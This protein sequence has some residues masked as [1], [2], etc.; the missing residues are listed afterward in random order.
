MNI[1]REMVFHC[2]LQCEDVQ[3]FGG[4]VPL[5]RPY[6]D[7]TILSS[8][9]KRIGWLLLLFVTG[10]LTGT[11]MSRFS[12][13][14]N[15]VIILSVFVPLL[16]APAVMSARRLLQP[17]FVLWLLAIFT[18][19]MHWQFYGESCVLCCFLDCCW[20]RADF[21]LPSPCGIVASKWRWW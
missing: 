18:H 7:T 13:L 10:T 3:R 1:R 20:P 9:G 17:S 16:L 4:S 19:V 14:L 6:L 11:V 8:V 2:P 12:E 21:W 5:R 15:S